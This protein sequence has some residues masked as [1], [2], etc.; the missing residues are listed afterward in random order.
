MNNTLIYVVCWILRF[1][2]LEFY[3]QNHVIMVYGIYSV[4]AEWVNEWILDCQLGERIEP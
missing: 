3:S 2:V 1:C 4:F